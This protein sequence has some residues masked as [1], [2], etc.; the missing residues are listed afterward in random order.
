[1]SAPAPVLNLP[2]AA[3]RSTLV[4]VLGWLAIVCGA[5]G[6][7]SAVVQAAFFNSLSD[8]PVAGVDPAV[9]EATTRSLT[10]MAF[11]NVAI[12]G[13]LMY[14]GYALW[15]RRDWARRTFVVLLA[16]GILANVIWFFF[17]LVFGSLFSQLGSGFGAVFG[18]FGIFAVGV[19]ALF[20]W[21]IKRLRSPAVKSEF[22]RRVDVGRA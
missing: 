13:F 16:L 10:V 9:K 22:A 3:G 17:S 18:V 5:L 19:A 2:A 15:K 8:M 6:I 7:L 21:F 20:V 14:V 11:L 4:S 12:S 1:M